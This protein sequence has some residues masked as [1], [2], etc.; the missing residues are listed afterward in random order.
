MTSASNVMYS[1]YKVSAIY[2]LHRVSKKNSQ[3]C[4][5]QN[6]VKFPPSLIIFDKKMAKMMKL[7]EVHSFSISPNLCQ[8]TT[9]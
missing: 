3:N 9:T 4:F 1:G 7:C 5:R 2:A 8:R 6:L